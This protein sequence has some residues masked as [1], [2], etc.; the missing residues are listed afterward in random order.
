MPV[1]VYALMYANITHELEDGNITAAQAD[2]MYHTVRDMPRQIDGGKHE[3]PTPAGSKPIKLVPTLR[4]QPKHEG[5][6]KDQKG[7]K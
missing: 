2:D 7:G 6:D 3:K 1:N 5:D 4:P